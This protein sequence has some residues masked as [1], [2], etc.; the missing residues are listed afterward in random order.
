MK[1]YTLKLSHKQQKP[2]VG[3]ADRLLLRRGGVQGVVSRVA[4]R[5]TRHEA[6]EGTRRSRTWAVATRNGPRADRLK[7][8][9][10]R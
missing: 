2:H 4:G 5:D 3:V 6:T 8:A 9:C 1:Q 7:G 10:E